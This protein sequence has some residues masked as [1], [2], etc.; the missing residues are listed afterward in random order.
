MTA[1]MFSQEW[2]AQLQQEWATAQQDP[3]HV[4][5]EDLHKRIVETWRRE[6]PKM[7]L[8]LQKAGAGAL[9]ARVVQQRMWKHQEELISSGMPVTDAREQAERA[10]L[11]LEPESELAEPT[12]QLTP[13]L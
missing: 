12:E 9:L 1:A 3:N 7:W 10:H 8:R 2:K 5:N 6:S 11:M 4:H 13:A